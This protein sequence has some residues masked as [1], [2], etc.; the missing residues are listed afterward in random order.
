MQGNFSLYASIFEEFNIQV[1]R[2][3][4]GDARLQRT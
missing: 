3:G 1:Y 2:E 4:N